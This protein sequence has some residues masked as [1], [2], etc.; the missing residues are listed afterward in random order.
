MSSNNWWKNLWIHGSADPVA[1]LSNPPPPCD[2][3][4]VGPGGRD[5]AYVL[6]A[7]LRV[8]AYVHTVAIR[9]VPTALRTFVSEGF[10][11]RG[12]SE[13][14][15]SMPA[16]WDDAAQGAALALL[17]AVDESAD[18]HG[19]PALGGFTAFRSPALG[20][21]RTL[22]V[23]WARG[24]ELPGV[25]GSVAMLAAVLLH[26]EEFDLVQEGHAARVLGR[27]AMR[28]RHFPFPYWWELR[29]APVLTREAMRA[30]VLEN[31][32]PRMGAGDARATRIGE[33]AYE[34]SLPD[35]AAE[36]FC[37]LWRELPTQ[38][39]F[40]LHTHLSP[41]AEAQYVWPADASGG[42]AVGSAT[43]QRYG[44][45]FA[46]LVGAGDDDRVRHIEDGLAVV[47]TPATFARVREALEHG[48]RIVVPLADGATF[49]VKVRPASL[50]DPFTGAALLA[51]GGWETH[52]PDTAAP[53]LG[54][55][56]L[57]RVVLM[58]S[59][60]DTRA[61]VDADTLASI[62]RAVHDTVESLA[63]RHPV[64]APVSLAVQLTLVPFR[65]PKVDV[66]WRGASA[67]AL[68]DPLRAALMAMPA[69]DVRDEVPLRLDLSLRAFPTGN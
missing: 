2:D 37:A 18:E 20:G 12:G 48:R 32:G 67:P 25:R 29:D 8:R 9:G 44:F 22:G 58:L 65:A 5:D 26:D 24:G 27:L 28:A 63:A 59:D 64:R 17:R 47:L 13:V 52:E 50:E 1:A 7:R 69:A 33:R 14:R 6:T 4:M 34:L 38:D 30:S 21:G 16:A 62:T 51:A 49:T 19:V 61:R 43:A 54:R 31:V 23:L 66:A 68:L 53:S 10:A 45:A 40:V 35:E 57:D 11:S 3:V 56:T 60:A 39:A 46:M 15:V 42:N 41:A 36:T 55:A